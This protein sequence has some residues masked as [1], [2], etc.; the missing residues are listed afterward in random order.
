MFDSLSDRFGGIFTRM[1]GRGRLGEKEVDDIAR[2]IRLA[3]LEAD[4]NFKV[5]KNFIGR[6]KEQAAG[7]E[8]SKSL[9]PAQ[10]VI[11]IVN[12][13]L[14]TTLGGTTGKLTMNP[15]PPTVVMLVGLQGSG[16][17]TACGKLAPPL[18]NHALQP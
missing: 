8:L 18:K 13:E 11:K 1:R 9:S 4:V 6:I 10:Q 3:L 16:N 7:A 14:V 15:K 2:E 17:T 5:V 12:Q